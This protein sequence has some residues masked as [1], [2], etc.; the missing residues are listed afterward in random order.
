MRRRR[1]SRRRT[2]GGQGGG[3]EEE[4]E[5]DEEE[6]GGREHLCVSLSRGM[7]FQKIY[8]HHAHTLSVGSS[9]TL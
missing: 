6:V 3:E 7:H 4:E 5:E 8:V 2:G 1:R 9:K